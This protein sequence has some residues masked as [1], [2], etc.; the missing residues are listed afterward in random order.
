[1]NSVL[2]ESPKFKSLGLSTFDAT[3]IRNLYFVP[4][5]RAKSLNR[6]RGDNFRDA[7]LGYMH[8]FERMSKT[9][10][11]RNHI[12]N[13]ELE[14]REV[15]ERETENIPQTRQTDLVT[16]LHYN[17]LTRSTDSS[18]NEER[19]KLEVNP[20]PERSSSD[21]SSETSLSDSRSKKKKRKKKKKR[22]K[23]R[24]DDSSDP[25]L[26]DDSDSSDDSDYRRNRLK[27]KKHRKNNPIK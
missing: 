24:K 15:F 3:D 22:R 21:S 1:M 19:H 18:K 26:S 5:T 7:R 25:S 8:D 9:I 27:N 2:S 4:Y 14:T 23:H 6:T 10:A 13:S 20:D 11:Y 16:T 12:K 17:P